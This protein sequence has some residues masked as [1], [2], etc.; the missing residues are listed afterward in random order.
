MTAFEWILLATMAVSNL[1]AAV[2]YTYCDSLLSREPNPYISYGDIRNE[3]DVAREFQKVKKYFFR[4][5]ESMAVFCVA[6]VVY[7]YNKE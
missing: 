1:S 4:A 3:E 5:M 7:A 6:A 2:N